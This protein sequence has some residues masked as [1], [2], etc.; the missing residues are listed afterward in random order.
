MV[1]EMSIV[2][3]T[4][5]GVALGAL[6]VIG[7]GQ[8]AHAGEPSDAVVFLVDT[9]SSMEGAPLAQ[10]QR[11]LARSLDAV[12]DDR[13][14]GLRTFAGGC[15]DPPATLVDPAVGNR[16]E[17][18]RAVDGL[19][20]S[21]GTPTGP[22][23]L[24]AARAL[25]GGSGT[26]VLISD[27]FAE[28]DPPPCVVAAALMEQGFDIR[29]NTVGYAFDGEPPSELTCVAEATGG[30]YFDADDEESLVAVLGEASGGGG[31]GAPPVPLL[32]VGVVGVGIVVWA[33]ARPTA[34]WNQRRLVRRRVR[35]AATAGRGVTWSPSRDADGEAP[36]R[37]VR[38]E[39]RPGRWE[40]RIVEGD[41]RG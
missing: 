2:R 13:A 26:I 32:I 30:R 1:I 12:P 35:V 20:A 21:G 5:V 27:G 6:A 17:L 23:L 16:E 29:I 3:R 34:P 38:L 40:A 24:T 41:D 8:A 7:I 18:R 10:A 39:V 19:F 37:S 14:V 15:D 22:A 31:G 36:T 9:S 25:S 11:A 28:C 4:A 33:A